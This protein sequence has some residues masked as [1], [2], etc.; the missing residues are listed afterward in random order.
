MENERFVPSVK[1]RSRGSRSRGGKRP[2]SDRRWRRLSMESLENRWLL[3]VVTVPWESEIEFNQFTGGAAQ[4][5]AIGYD[6]FGNETPRFAGIPIDYN[7]T[8]G[9]ITSDPLFGSRW[10]GKATVDVDGRIGVE[11]GV[12]ADAGTAY[13]L[14][15]GTFSYDIIDAG[16]EIGINTSVKTNDGALFSLSPRLL[17][18][19]DMVVNVNGRISGE[20]CAIVCGS[21]STSLNI[22]EKIEL[23]SVN[24][25]NNGE[26]KVIGGAATSELAKAVKQTY[27]DRQADKKSKKDQYKSSKNADGYQTVSDAERNNKSMNK[28]GQQQGS[29]GGE[30]L[31]FSFK[32]HPSDLLGVQ[33]DASIGVGVKR[34]ANL[35][36]E[37]GFVGITVPDISLVDTSVDSM[38]GL[39]AS[40]DSFGDMALDDRRKIFDVGVDFAA[41]S[42]IGGKKT[43]ELGPVT[44]ELTLF[45]YYVTAD[46][47]VNQDLAATPVAT[48]VKFAFTDPNNPS[49]PVFLT[50]TIDGESFPPTSAIQF[51]AG[52]NVKINTPSTVTYP[53]G[54]TVTPQVI[55]SF[56]VNND[57]GLDL[58][59]TGKLRALEVKLS[60]AGEEVFKRGPLLSIDTPL[61]NF[62]LGSVYNTTYRV[63]GN[64]DDAI[65]PFRIGGRRSDLSV[66]ITSLDY[67]ENNT[68]IDL[69]F[70]VFNQGP[71]TAQNV[72]VTA[73]VPP[74]FQFNSSTGN[75]SHN[76]A[77]DTVTCSIG[78]L[79]SGNFA[80]PTVTMTP[81]GVNANETFVISAT[82]T[83]TEPDPHPRNNSTSVELFGNI[84]E[85]FVVNSLGDSE[86]L[87]DPC[88]ER[89]PGC[90]LREAI[91]AANEADGRDAIILDSGVLGASTIELTNG[92]LVI[93]E[94]VDILGN[95]ITIRN[96]SMTPSR[97]FRLGKNNGVGQFRF[98]GL[99]LSG[100]TASDNG[101]A[102]SLVDNDGNDKLF[103]KNTLITGNSAGISGG[104]ISIQGGLLRL[105]ENV[106]FI[107][108]TAAIGGG[109]VYT[110][111]NVANVSDA[112][113]GQNRV[114]SGQGGGLLLQ[115]TFGATLTR[116][117]VDGN[118]AS[119]GGGGIGHSAFG[120]GRTSSLTLVD[121]KIV[122]NTITAGRGAGLNNIPFAG[123]IVADVMYQGSVFADNIELTN[124]TSTNYDFNGFARGISNGMN[125]S[126]DETLPL[127]PSL[128]D[129][130]NTD[131]ITISPDFVPVNRFGALAGFL[132]VNV[133]TAGQQISYSVSHPDFEVFAGGLRLKNDRQ[134]T[135]VGFFDVFVTASDENGKSWSQF[136]R[137]QVIGPPSAPSMFPPQAPF[138]DYVF[139]QWQ[140]SVGE[141]E[142]V[143]Y[144]HDAD[145]IK[146]IKYLPANTTSTRIDGLQPLTEYTFSVAAFNGA[147]AAT[148]G[149]QSITLP[150]PPPEIPTN[151]LAETTET[152]T[153]V[154]SWDDV[155]HEASYTVYR[156][157]RNPAGEGFTDT[158]LI[159]LPANQT[160]VEL[161]NEPPDAMYFI[162]TEGV[163]AGFNRTI[164]VEPQANYPFNELINRSD[165][166]V[167]IVDDSDQGFQV[168]SGTWLS[169]SSGFRGSRRY[170]AA[171][172]GSAKVRWVFD[173]EPGEYRVSTT[174]QPAAEN[175]MF[176]MFSV[177]DS[178][179]FLGGRPFDQQH[180]PNDFVADGAAWEDLLSHVTVDDTTLIV[181]AAD[182]CCGNV[183]AD[184]IRI[185]RLG[186]SF[187]QVADDSS[188]MFR[189]LGSGW[190]ESGGGFQGGHRT[191]AGGNGVD[192]ARWTFA[193]QP[194]QYEVLARWPNFG[195][196]AT[197]APFKIFD[198]SL[199][200]ATVAV[201][202]QESPDDVLLFDG[203][204]ERLGTS[205][206][207]QT[208]TLTVQLSDDQANGNV[209]ADAIRIQRIGGPRIQTLDDGDAGF[210]VFGS[211]WT[212]AGAG[213]RGDR[214]QLSP[215]GGFASTVWK[216]DV[217]P[218]VYR[219]SATWTHA[220]DR[221]SNAKFTILD[222]N[223]PLA[224]VTVGQRQPPN[225][226]FGH[227]S[228]WED[229]G[230][231][232]EVRTN[233]LVVELL[234]SAG[235]VVIAD[236]VL[237][238]DGIRIQRIGGPTTQ[239]IDDGQLGFE[240]EGT[241]WSNSNFGHLG[242]D[243]TSAQ[244]TE[245][246]GY[247]ANVAR[248]SF[249]VAPGTYQV[250][251]AW[252]SFQA[253]NVPYAIFDGD[254]K[255][256][257]IDF[258]DTNGLPSRRR[259][260]DGGRLIATTLVN[261]AASPNDFDDAGTPWEN[262]VTVP[263]SSGRLVVEVS[264]KALNPMRDGAVNGQI[265]ADAIRVERVGG[266][267]LQ[268]IDDGDAGFSVLT[269]SW[270]AR[271]TGSQNDHRSAPRG[272]GEA[273]TRWTFEVNP[274][275]YRVSATWLPAA[276]QATNAP[277][278]FYDGQ[279]PLFT[280]TAD[281]SKWPQ[282][283]SDGG[284]HWQDLSNVIT[285]SSTELVVELANAADGRV[286]ADAL[287]VERFDGRVWQNPA[288]AFDIDG[289]NGVTPQDA[290]ILVNYLNESG[291]GLLPRPMLDFQPAPY[292]DVNGD[293]LVSALDLILLV[294]HLNEFEPQLGLT[295]GGGSNSPDPMAV[296]AEGEYFG[297][298]DRLAS[299]LQSM[300]QE[301]LPLRSVAEAVFTDSEAGQWEFVNR[302]A[303][304]VSD[305]TASTALDHEA[306]FAN[307]SLDW[308]LAEA[309]R[310]DHELFDA[311]VGRSG[312][313]LN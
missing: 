53:D 310:D 308:D 207:V 19:A 285:V 217:V 125:L 54:A 152:G 35:A 302:H 220:S 283:F 109:G 16:A 48:D 169:D 250:A 68:A 186:E 244:W 55:K 266:L 257:D 61:A 298:Q 50:G 131:P 295:S 259:G 145:G 288:N 290:V 171:G 243:R 215:G 242:D 248:W 86:R 219:V 119:D 166:L 231:T 39:F 105:E 106:R 241:G 261:Q 307:E 29:G 88:R 74:E 289:Q 25:H 36:N 296:A 216:F 164:A 180:A 111:N 247:N 275:Q 218:G 113:F 236:G 138:Y 41:F 193:V 158:M 44:G 47:K 240:L 64:T 28:S 10:G 124:F 81:T 108:N 167:A 96:G 75:C 254:R 150:P 137:I 155:D 141:D 201:N 89:A 58:D 134:A 7:R 278:A 34:G 6:R 139:L 246:D 107:N 227:G 94:S 205:V 112:F 82:V 209:T 224:T 232:F 87:D 190:S 273:K 284:V 245:I 95:G 31:Q 78:N 46:L 37:I 269:G 311:I 140:D 161:M 162:D 222:F 202:Q 279:T 159:E 69:T 170:K 233:D 184:A 117:T 11:Y 51:P 156:R 292:Y 225:D 1:S 144:R 17:A 199:E 263:I 157:T 45:S 83:A 165:P 182:S 187:H 300:H 270:N 256:T 143:V 9:G 237:V 114:E 272:S 214:Q 188:P 177:H 192:V 110:L 40:T 133:P 223:N 98:K 92:E 249:D 179:D 204:W 8:L 103:I 60:I 20:A 313:P 49:N 154:V 239:I 99:T 286:I 22:N 135:S 147:G 91:R 213:H 168:Q 260:A 299:S 197:N 101:G 160:R 33:V 90:T 118:F 178:S 63:A 198:G 253:T 174:W 120:A 206:S 303:R 132:R 189:T 76:A 194:G 304:R 265:T 163:F 146:P 14:N 305:E 148:F 153:I 255:L 151:L 77:A 56:D 281:Q 172:D 271:P 127:N 57:I 115:N 5:L 210:Q 32:E 268:V 26:I 267:P 228:W 142:Y 175:S 274:G 229:L 291:P 93:T 212:V 297:D 181:E 121:S 136:V 27:D 65:T 21:G 234:N 2:A 306:V 282:S 312:Q 200:L 251:A 238:A 71:S 30:I 149:G 13:V 67:V 59:L 123:A 252:V 100:G 116:T 208:G 183:S 43:L 264:N 79:S 24:R 52:A 301:N 104:G 185:E 84:P 211:D 130:V 85:V 18:F 38:G 173:V 230:T 12:F 4:K 293:N 66:N 309:L 277:Y 80:N 97:L 73:Q 221:A 128:G 23:A 191:S 287:R 280:T 126:D 258:F 62:D 129:V 42:G 195:D 72:S 3:A 15:S 203:S 196:A 176:A 235:G 102:I 294:N 276:G 70:G 262:L 122:N 226:F